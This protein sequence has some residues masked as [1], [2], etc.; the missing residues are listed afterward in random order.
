MVYQPDRR[1]SRR[2]QLREVPLAAVLPLRRGIATITMSRGQWDSLL[3]AAYDLNW[4][5]LELDDAERPVAA[6]RKSGPPVATEAMAT[7]WLGGASQ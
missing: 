5:L 7:S 4:I 2:P 1:K 6:Y 3:Q